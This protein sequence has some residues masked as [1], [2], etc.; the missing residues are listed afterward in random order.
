MMSYIYISHHDKVVFLALD[1][2]S[3]VRK[4]SLESLVEFKVHYHS[5]SLWQTPALTRMN[6]YLS[7]GG[8]LTLKMEVSVWSCFSMARAAGAFR[9]RS[10]E[11]PAD[12]FSSD[13]ASAMKPR[14]EGK[15]FLVTLCVEVWVFQHL[16]CPALPKFSRTC[17]HLSLTSRR[18]SLMASMSTLRRR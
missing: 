17:C 13:S 1:S 5:D 10:C 12:T 7:G 4:P 3:R 18:V 9:M 2:R 16:I 15:P 6:R 11:V 8:S 14:R